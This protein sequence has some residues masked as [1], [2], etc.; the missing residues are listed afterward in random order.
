V[1]IEVRKTIQKIGGT[2]PENLPAA[3][4]IKKLKKKSVAPQLPTVKE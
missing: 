2:M 4:S 1:G 3:P